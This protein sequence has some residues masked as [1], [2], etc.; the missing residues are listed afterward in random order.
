[1]AIAQFNFE[2]MEAYRFIPKIYQEKGAVF[3][4]ENVDGWI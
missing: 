1:M 2:T 3:G 4:N